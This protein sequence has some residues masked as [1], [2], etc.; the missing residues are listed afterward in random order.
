MNV[1]S[2]QSEKGKEG[3]YQNAVKEN[4]KFQGV[5]VKLKMYI[6]ASKVSFNF[7]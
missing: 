5:P 1:I 4:I 2:M 3:K 6:E 7:E